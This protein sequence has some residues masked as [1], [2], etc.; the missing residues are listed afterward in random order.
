MDEKKNTQ[1]E[2]KTGVDFFV[3]IHKVDKELFAPLDPLEEA[4]KTD[5]N[6]KS[7]LDFFNNILSLVLLY[8]NSSQGMR[9]VLSMGSL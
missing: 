9:R 1:N 3:R 8:P 2:K 5:D 6:N 7:V 4:Q